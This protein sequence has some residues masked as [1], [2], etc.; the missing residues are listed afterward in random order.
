MRCGH[1]YPFHVVTPFKPISDSIIDPLLSRTFLA[2]T[3]IGTSPLQTVHLKHRSHPDLTPHREAWMMISGVH[4][5]RHLPN[6]GRG[7]LDSLGLGLMRSRLTQRKLRNA[8]DIDDF[9][10]GFASEA[11]RKARIGGL[12]S[13]SASVQKAY[14]LVRSFAKH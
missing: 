3:L 11:T 10:D 14:D 7:R 9:V 8:I 12:F 13:A 6:K 1:H 4:P 5:E 2:R